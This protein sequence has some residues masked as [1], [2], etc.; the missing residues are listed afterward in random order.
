M[1]INEYLTRDDIVRFTAKSDL[2]AWRLVLGNWLAIAAIFGVVGAYPNP[3]VILFAMIL[4][5]G[6]QLGLSV[7][8]HEAGHRTLFATP[9]LND[10]VGQWL[11]AAPVFNDLPA[12]A[13]G[14]LDHHRKAGTR[15]DPDLPNYAAYPISRESFRRKVIRDL[16]GQ[17]GIKFL[18]FIFRGA[19]G[20]IS[21]EK[22]EGSLPLLR[23]LLVQF[24]LFLVLFAA[25]T[26]WAYLVWL[27]AFLT[28]FMLII[29]IRQVAEHA[30]VPDLYDPD[31]RMNT[32]TVDAPW[33]QRMVFAPNGVNFH[34]EHHF[35]ASVPCYRLAALRSHLKRCRALDG[36][37]VFLGYG[38]LLRHAVGPAHG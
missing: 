23:Q 19:S 20:V 3:F 2:Q 16:S 38:Q 10:V 35:M 14:H 34:L 30:A 25:G 31:P 36:V 12:Y 26:G 29:R 13:R 27:G 21:R 9:W 24:L 11:C 32:R 6:R 8:M 1:K 33:W 15:E 17:T 7:L 5:A 4:L 28:F 37:P 18:G 22:R